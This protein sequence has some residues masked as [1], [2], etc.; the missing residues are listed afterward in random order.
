MEYKEIKPSEATVGD[1]IYT[2]GDSSFCQGGYSMI[3]GFDTEYDKD[4][5]PYVVITDEEEHKYRKDTGECL[6]GAMAYSIQGY[7][8]KTYIT[9]V[10]KVERPKKQDFF[11]DDKSAFLL[12]ACDEIYSDEEV[13]EA[14]DALV[15]KVYERGV[16]DGKA[17]MKDTIIQLVRNERLDSTR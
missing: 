6:K 8:R 3:V 11:K 16:R 2:D 1:Y 12:K 17:I 7:A 10:T 4:G 5:T 13:L 9:F 14:L 15:L